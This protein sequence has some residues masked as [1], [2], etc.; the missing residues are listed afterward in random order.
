MVSGKPIIGIARL[1][2]TYGG[3]TMRNKRVSAS[4]AAVTMAVGILVAGGAAAEAAPTAASC[5]VASHPAIAKIGTTIR[6]SVTVANCTATGT[7]AIQRLLGGA[8]I[9]VKSK[10]ITI[11]SP[12]TVDHDCSGSGL[13]SWRSHLS[14]NIDGTVVISTSGPLRV[15]C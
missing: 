5:S 7:L 2:H 14:L 9:N 10:P 11:G 4:L 6:T 3:N 1:D 12:T 13:Q 15:T 8:W